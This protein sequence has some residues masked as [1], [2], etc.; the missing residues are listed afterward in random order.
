MPCL[1]QI[2]STGDAN[3]AA[4]Q[5]DDT[6]NFLAEFSARLPDLPL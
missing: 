5:N 3:D 4:T 2:I 1:G 6:H